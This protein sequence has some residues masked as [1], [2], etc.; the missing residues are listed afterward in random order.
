MKTITVCSS[1]ELAA[2]IALQSPASAGLLF[3]RSPALDMRSDRLACMET[4]LAL[5]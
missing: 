1:N 3:W 5:H 2:V 4:I